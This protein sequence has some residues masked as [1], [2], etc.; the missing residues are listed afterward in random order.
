MLT[1]RWELATGGQGQVVSLGGEAGI[2]KS[3]IVAEFRQRVANNARRG[4]VPML[5]LSRP[6]RVSPRDRATQA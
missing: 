4:R 2:G 3:R 5:S 1:R 6:C